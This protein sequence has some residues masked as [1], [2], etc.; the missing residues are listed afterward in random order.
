MDQS[1][2]R[3]LLAEGGFFIFLEVPKGTE[4]GIDMK[5]WNTGE[6][7]RG[8][9][10][11]PPGVHFIFYSAV[12]NTDDIA[13]RMGF[14]HNFKKSEVLVKK[15]DKKT[16]DISM[17]LVSEE[18]VVNLKE[19]LMMLDEFLGPYP[20]DILD[21]WKSLT[22]NI[23]DNLLCKLTPRS[24]QVKSALELQSC[25]DAE[26]PKGIKKDSPNMPSCSYVKKARLTE[27]K[28]NDLLPVLKPVEGTELRFTPFPSKNYPEDA[29][30]SQ[31]TQHSLDRTYV[32]EKMLSQYSKPMEIIGELEFCFVC[33]LVGHSLEAFDQW[34]KLVTLFCSCDLAVRKYRQ[35]FDVF[36]TLLEIHIKE[37]PEEF[38]ADIVSNNNFVYVNLKKI[39]RTI[40]SSDVDGQLKTKIDRF[41]NSLTATYLWDFGHLD[42]EEED[43]APVVVK[44]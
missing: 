22:A 26:R 17:E 35:I 10:M 15:W 43:E 36:I 29:S 4:F 3:R 6:K 37:I 11:I 39:F 30:P 14:F 21:K 1:T 18:E 42:S 33:F 27:S 8:V 24:G 13:P 28:E 38:L 34:K 9:K 25:S 31:I 5:S 32:F 41:R 7:F 19:N 20:Y 12:S 40:Q 23:T 2:A 16:E 44:T